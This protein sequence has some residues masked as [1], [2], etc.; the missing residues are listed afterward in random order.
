MP[1]SK[2]NKRKY[3][4]LDCDFFWK[5]NSGE[6][7]RALRNRFQ[8]DGIMFYIYLQSQI[9]ST[10]E[11]YFKEYNEDWLYNVS[12]DLQIT[13]DKT[14]QIIKLLC[15]KSML[16]SKLLQEHNV[17][18]STKIQ[19]LFQDLVQGI[20]AKRKIVVDGRLWL[21]DESQTEGFIE[22]C[23][24]LNKSEIYSDKSKKCSDKSKKYLLREVKE[25]KELEDK[26]KRSVPPQAAASL[27]RKEDLILDYG[28][29]AVTEYERRFDEWAKGK[30]VGVD[31]YTEISKW[32]WRD[33]HTADTVSKAVKGENSSFNIAE[34]E[35]LIKHRA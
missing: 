5:E 33:Y 30:V 17:M 3:F 6:N 2:S 34:I 22:V 29:A 24:S 13:P 10:D 1:K 19:L 14:R 20:G 23:N 4:S 12:S 27:S 31:K 11:G 21:L 25:E 28:K 9:F 16:D 26:A 32:L 18:T 8:N 15:E 35:E 7:Y